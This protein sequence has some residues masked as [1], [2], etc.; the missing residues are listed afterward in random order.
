VSGLSIKT[1]SEALEQCCQDEIEYTGV[2][3]KYYPR[4]ADR[5]VRLKGK[6]LAALAA[7]SERMASLEA[8]VAELYERIG[9]EGKY[10]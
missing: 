1:L 6:L 7:K 10:R 2:W 9:N 5:A 8:K 3:R 4:F